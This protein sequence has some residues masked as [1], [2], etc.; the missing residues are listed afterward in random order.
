[1]AARAPRGRHIDVPGAHHEI[2]LET[3][4]RRQVFWQA[5]DTLADEVAPR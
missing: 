3:D 1:L 4:A 2:L 5:F